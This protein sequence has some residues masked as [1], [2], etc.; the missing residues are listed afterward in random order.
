MGPS[1]IDDIRRGE[2]R[3]PLGTDFPRRGVR[4]IRG[5]RQPLREIRV[6][7]WSRMDEKAALNLNPCDGPTSV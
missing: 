2:T 7:Q 3:L 1:P 6:G 5:Y 4:I